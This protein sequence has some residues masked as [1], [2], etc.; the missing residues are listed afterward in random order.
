MTDFVILRET[1]EFMYV[2]LACLNS[3]I[4]VSNVEPVA[5]EVE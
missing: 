3:Q 4:R 2:F 1:A 5:Y